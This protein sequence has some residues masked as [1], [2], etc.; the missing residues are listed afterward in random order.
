MTIAYLKGNVIEVTKNL[1]NRMILVID[2]NNIG[3]E[4]QITPRFSRQL[5]AE[6]PETLQVF[7]HLQIQEDRQIL[8]GFASATE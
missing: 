7:T 5:A 3:Y 4:V 8:Y 2:V 1:S 6:N